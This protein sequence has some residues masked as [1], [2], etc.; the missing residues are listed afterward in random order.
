MGDPF[1]NQCEKLGFSEKTNPFIS[2]IRKYVIEK[3]YP[4][5]G[6]IYTAIHNAVA[7]GKLSQE[8]LKGTV[9]NKI[10]ILNCKDLYTKSAKEITDYFN[11]FNDIYSRSEYEPNNIFSI[12]INNITDTDRKRKFRAIISHLNRDDKSRNQMA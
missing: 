1:R 6:S 9:G 3:N 10:N 12:D 2:F 4:I 5:G 11:Y 8:L 7:T